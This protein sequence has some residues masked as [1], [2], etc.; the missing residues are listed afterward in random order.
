MLSDGSTGQLL[1]CKQLLQ[2]LTSSY[3]CEVTK[4]AGKR[5]V[6]QALQGH[7]EPT[8]ATTINK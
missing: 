2:W 6:Q 5:Y 3:E 1:W 8:P 7:W 4:S